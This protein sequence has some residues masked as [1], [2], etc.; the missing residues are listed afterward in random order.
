M[1]ANQTILAACVRLAGGPNGFG[2]EA[3]L[4]EEEI[5]LMAWRMNPEIFGLPNHRSEYPDSKRVACELASGKIIINQ[6]Y[7]RRVAPRM[8]RLTPAGVKLGEWV[9]EGGCKRK[10]E[11]A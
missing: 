1:T 8:Y 11:T 5:I 3:T 7:L 10:K 2:I 4:P 9:L 6:G